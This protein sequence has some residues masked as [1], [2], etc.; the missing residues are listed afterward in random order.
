MT[1]IGPYILK[2][3]GKT[4]VKFS[5]FYAMY[6]NACKMHGNWDMQNARKML[7]DFDNYI[8][9]MKIYQTQAKHWQH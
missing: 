7:G 1:K 8:F 3:S 4:Q 5:L 6:K 9:Q 2:N